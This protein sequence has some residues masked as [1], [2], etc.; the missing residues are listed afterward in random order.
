MPTLRLTQAE[1]IRRAKA[2]HGNKFS[3]KH[4]V[5]DTVHVPVA[6]TCLTHGEFQQKPSKHLRGQGCP[7]C[8]ANN[9]ST[10]MSNR[11]VVNRTEFLERSTAK[12]G[13]VF[14]Y[15]RYTSFT[16][17]LVI[18][19]PMH[20]Q[21]VT[22]P[23][24]HLRTKVGCP[25]CGRN[26]STTEQ[27]VVAA[28]EVHG[29]KYDYSQTICTT[30]KDQVTIIC[31]QHGKFYIVQ[32]YHINGQGCKQCGLDRHAEK[33]IQVASDKY[34]AA[35]KKIHG[36]RYDYTLTDYT[37]RHQYIKIK[38]RKHGVFEQTAGN[39]LNGQDCPGCVPVGHSKI[40]IR[41]IE[42]TAKSL[43]LKDVWHAENGGEF[44]VPGTKYRVDGYHA[45]TNTIFEF[46]GDCF[47]GN[48]KLY[49]KTAYPNPFRNK[50]AAELY[51]ATMRR[52]RILR[53]LGY[54][55]VS[56]WEHDYRKSLNLI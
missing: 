33:R 44:C 4:V 30:V 46:Y 42:E 17:D 43:R 22:T 28:R 56:V 45:R 50:T 54:E 53:K 49:L 5:L 21:F 41:W 55:I 32:R 6:I 52:E 15:G 25:E 23:K 1:F 19:C 37:G 20:G 9:H 11:V 48:P 16:A 38:C 26:R 34:L 7:K 2:I 27:F 29:E 13:N 51:A 39:H 8:S 10:F 3:Y 18:T 31:P 14:S 12:F 40:S 35:V 24:A 47:H 36:T